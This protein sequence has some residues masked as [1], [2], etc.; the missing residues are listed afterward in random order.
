VPGALEA[1]LGFLR[2]GASKWPLD[3]LRDAG[4]DLEQAEPVATALTRFGAL[5]DELATLL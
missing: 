5:V 2:S 4:V 3:L 1:Y